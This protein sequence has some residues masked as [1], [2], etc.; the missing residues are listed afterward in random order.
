MIKKLLHLRNFFLATDQRV[1]LLLSL[2]AL[3]VYTFC[4][5][6]SS[7]EGDSGEL[8]AAAA[9]LGVAHPTGFPLYLLLGKLFAVLI[10]FGEIAAR[11][12]F[13]SAVAAA[14]TVGIMYLTARAMGIARWASFAAVLCLIFAD[15]FWGH[16]T[17]ARVYSLVAFFIAAVIWAMACW[18]RD[19]KDRQLYLAALFLGL[20]FGTHL[21]IVL[22]L[23]VVLLVVAMTDI[24]VF[25][26]PVFY[27]AMLLAFVLGA[28]Q[29]LYIP[30][31]GATNQAVNYGFPTTWESFVAYIT[32]RDYAMKMAS[33]TVAGTLKAFFA[34]IRLFV[35][36]FTPAGFLLALVGFRELA[37]RHKTWAVALGVLVAAN[38]LMMINYGNEEDLFILYRYFLPSYLVMTL[39]LGLAFE[40]IRRVLDRA[41]AAP[42]PARALFLLIA[43]L[44]LLNLGAHAGRNDRGR[45]LIVRDYATNV[46]DSVPHG[47]VL[48]S[49]GDA[50]SG[51]LLYLREALGM[52]RD[53]ILE[54]K[55][56]LT[57]P[58]YASKVQERYKDWGLDGYSSIEPEKKVDAFIEAARRHHKE[59]Y[60]T[61]LMLET[62]ENVPQGV[63]YHL[64]PKGASTDAQAVREVNHRLWDHYALRGTDKPASPRDQEQMVREIVQAYGKSLNNAALYFDNAGLTD[65]AR[66]S[67]EMALR[68]HPDDF[69]A[70]HNLGQLYGRLGD[71]ARAASFT[72]RAAV[73]DPDFFARMGRPG[74][75]GKDYAVV[76][77]QRKA[78]SAVDGSAQSFIE[79]GIYYGTR[80]DHPR[81]VES[82]KKA[83]EL[84][85]QMLAAH[86]NLGNA[87]MYLG[88]IDA[89]MSAFQSA[90]RIDP[91]VASAS[92]YLNLA[93]LYNNNK[94]DFVA[95]AQHMEKFLELAPEAPQ[96]P[97]L[98]QQLEYIKAMAQ[99][100]K[101]G[102]L[103]K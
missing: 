11:I 88:D 87:Y 48:L 64:L 79:K 42:R 68:F 56:Y 83:T 21:S 8:L 78:E 27:K 97:A 86:I 82:F 91:G 18:C 73:I 102:T 38:L 41:W 9:T 50:V 81:A 75:G 72:R 54:D 13:V 62:C 30:W 40:S 63:L 92:A 103:G 29:Y 35:L 53:I 80:G 67:Y 100:Q 1:A 96:A 16:A 84:E 46:L 52:R 39:C 6:P 57:R 20:G 32:Q 34:S 76:P 49:T 98:R 101:E 24:R 3:S 74:A 70:L 95:A 26:R 19:R 47:A 2:A 7:Y 12:N 37:R 23:P 99:A 17:V 4:L 77:S 36:E 15:T 5:C 94:K 43:A 28:G 66:R 10:P 93:A 44:A 59:V 60:A 22:C 31:A 45:D 90:L 71:Q 14:A 61:F 25:L 58:W 65:E 33:R 69:A 55:S 51:T 89:A 85:P